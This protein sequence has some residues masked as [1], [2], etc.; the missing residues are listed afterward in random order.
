MDPNEIYSTESAS[1]RKGKMW[2][3]ENEDERAG[4]ERDVEREKERKRKLRGGRSH[5]EMLGCVCV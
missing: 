2:R 5:E 4:D 1:R 3:Y